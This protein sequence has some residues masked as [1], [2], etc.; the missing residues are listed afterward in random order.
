MML[1]LVAPNP[2]AAIALA[3]RLYPDRRLVGEPVAISPAQPHDAR[4]FCQMIKTAKP[5]PRQR[6]SCNPSRS[7]RDARLNHHAL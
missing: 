4:M 2:E 7:K 3:H 1:T 6:P 5:H